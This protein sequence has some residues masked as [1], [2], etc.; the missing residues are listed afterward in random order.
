[1][2]LTGVWL[3]HFGCCHISNSK[4]CFAHSWCV[5]TA[6]ECSVICFFLWVFGV[7]QMPVWDHRQHPWLHNMVLGDAFCPL[8]LR[9][10]C[11][12]FL[13]CTDST[14]T[15]RWFE[16]VGKKITGSFC[17][18]LCRLCADDTWWNLSCVHHTDHLSL[19]VYFAFPSSSGGCSKWP[20]PCVPEMLGEA[21]CLRASE[22]Q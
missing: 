2:G 17:W 11:C 4:P 18:V 7:L 16:S 10:S 13:V 3:F 15:D 22:M 19:D 9:E 12:Q 20:V 1:M 21:W 8:S 14:K 5:N 6:S